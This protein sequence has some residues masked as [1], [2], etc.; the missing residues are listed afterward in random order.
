[1]HNDFLKKL[2]MDPFFCVL[3][4]LIPRNFLLTVGQRI[5]ID[6]TSR[7]TDPFD[8]FSGRGVDQNPL[9]RIEV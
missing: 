9:P 6:K 3:E 4:R 7:L 5:K 1:M 8:E 2:T